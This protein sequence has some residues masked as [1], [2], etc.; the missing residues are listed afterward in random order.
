MR[1][2]PKHQTQCILSIRKIEC[3]VS[4]TQ[5]TPICRNAHVVVN[6]GQWGLKSKTE[7]SAVE[8]DNL[9]M[10]V[11]IPER[12]IQNESIRIEIINSNIDGSGAVV[13]S[14]SLRTLTLFRQLDE[15]VELKTSF[16]NSS[17]SKIG[18]KAPAVLTA[19]S[20]LMI[21]FNPSLRTLSFK[22]WF[23]VV[24]L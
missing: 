6:F 5:R 23:H 4:E 16:T 12:I 19:P 17:G 2:S 9:N 21:L 11:N 13:G 14:A 3:F 20:G 15:E 18:S 24:M 7:I 22:L 10:V 1:R 8:W